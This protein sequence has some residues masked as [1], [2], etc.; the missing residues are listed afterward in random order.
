MGKHANLPFHLYV[1]VKNEY[2]GPSMPAGVTKGAWHGVYCREYQVLMCHVLL[3]SGAN[4]SGLP[5]HSLSTTE[6]FSVYQED[7]MPWTAMGEEIESFHT[8]MLEGLTADVF[9]PLKTRG[10]HTGI[11]IDWA[12]GYSRYPQ[13]HKPLNLIHLNSG[14]FALLPNNYVV[15]Q[16]K[17]FVDEEAKKNLKHY[18]R[19]E[20]IYWEI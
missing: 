3:E 9:K 17:H 14:Q 5:L 8:T 11:I 4:W 1:N 18:K 20:N 13:E 6:D 15:Y 2:L 10:R 12:D 7:L 19:G 16:D